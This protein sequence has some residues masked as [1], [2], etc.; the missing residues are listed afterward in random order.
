M[1]I[2]GIGG[3]Q[4]VQRV[5]SNPIQ[6]TIP[7]ESTA[8][9]P[10]DRLELSGLSGLLKTAKQNDIRADKVADIKAQIEAGKYENDEKLDIATDRLLD[11]L[12]K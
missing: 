5:I 10:S 6:K 4:P 8:S 9:K 3:S 11:D 12:L 1:S 7:T 2:N